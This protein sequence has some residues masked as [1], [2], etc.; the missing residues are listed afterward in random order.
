LQS[1]PHV[2]RVEN[3]KQSRAGP[4]ASRDEVVATLTFDF[5]SN[6]FRPE[7][8]D[9]WRTTVNIA[10]PNLVHG[11]S[12]QN[13]QNLVKP[14]NEFRNRVA[15]HEPVLDMNINDVHSRIVRLVALRCNETAAWMKHHSTVHA[16]VR[17]RPKL[18]GSSGH[19]LA[20]RLDKTFLRVNTEMA[21]KDLL[22]AVDERHPAIVCVG[23]NGQPRAAF[24]ILDAMRFVSARAKE[25]DGLIALAEHK[26]SH[27]L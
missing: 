15:H 11:E 26:V 23:E 17:T 22:E 18:D 10:F 8:G 21:L 27:L 20:A 3:V 24:T 5:W 19:T 2:G 16:V 1:N 13:L 12:R 25:C 4:T 7:Y 14:T 9:L 6:L